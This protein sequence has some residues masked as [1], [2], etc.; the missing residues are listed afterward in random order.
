MK[1]ILEIAKC[2]K[3]AGDRLRESKINYK[4]KIQTVFNQL[5]IA[6]TV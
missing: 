3:V 4:K 2:T 1:K 6:M 5:R